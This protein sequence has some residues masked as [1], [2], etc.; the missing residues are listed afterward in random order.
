M[1]EQEITQVEKSLE[2]KLPSYY[3]DFMGDYP[4]SKMDIDS[5]YLEM[6]NN[7]L[8]NDP[9]YLTDLNENLK[10]HQDNG[11][12]Q[13][14]FCI[15][16]N[17]GGDFYLINIQNLSDKAVYLFDHEESAENHYNPETKEWDWAQLKVFD[18]LAEYSEWIGELFEGS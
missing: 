10:F 11:Y 8:I 6:R 13:N 4:F 5:P 3:I 16:E 18:S 7:F 9:A 1:N 17:G 15:G 2:I 12:I 14:R